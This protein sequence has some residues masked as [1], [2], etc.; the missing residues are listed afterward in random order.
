MTKFRRH[1]DVLADDERS[2][3]LGIWISFTLL[4]MALIGVVIWAGTPC[5]KDGWQLLERCVRNTMP[6]S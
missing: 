5:S 3:H 6:P 2:E 1:T 4:Y